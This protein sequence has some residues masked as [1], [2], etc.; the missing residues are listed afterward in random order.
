MVENGQADAQPGFLRRE[1]LADDH[2]VA[3][4]KATLRQAENG[5]NDVER[6]EPV[7]RQIKRERDGLHDGA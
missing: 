4:D 2:R 3:R 5:R 6:N 7:K 1:Q